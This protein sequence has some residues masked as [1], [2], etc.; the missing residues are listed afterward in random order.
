[1]STAN[2]DG[3]VAAI[4]PAGLSGIAL[5]GGPLALHSLAVASS[6]RTVG[7]IVFA[8]SPIARHGSLASDATVSITLTI[9]DAAGAAFG[10]APVYL[11]FQQTAGGGSAAV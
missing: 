4:L 6:A 10:G 5:G 7:S 9:K 8:P 3:P 11:Y 1:G 2:R